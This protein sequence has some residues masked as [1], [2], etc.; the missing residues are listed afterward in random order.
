M[1]LFSRRKD[2][3]PVDLEERA[4][5]TGV[6]YKDLLVLQQ[7]LRAGADLGAPRHVLHYLYLPSQTAANE[8]AAE[9]ARAGYEVTVGE[10]LPDYP[11]QWS[12]RCERHGH[13][14]SMDG[15]RDATDFF[16]ALAERLAGL[17]DGWEAAAN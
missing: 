17:Y 2:R 13:V 16:E 5:Q 3:T 12:V 11:D 1:A 4:P 14:L 6:K 9:A 10:P 8:A 15:V 7:L